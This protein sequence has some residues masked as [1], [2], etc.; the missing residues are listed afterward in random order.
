MENSHSRVFYAYIAEQIQIH[1]TK[2]SERRC[3]NDSYTM[4]MAHA[5]HMHGSTR[6]KNIRKNLPFEMMPDV[7][8]I[9]SLS[10]KKLHTS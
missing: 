5:L 1:E 3:P 4:A 7:R 9:F 6:H 2:S 8:T 10:E